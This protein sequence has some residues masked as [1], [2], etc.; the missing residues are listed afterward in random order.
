MNRKLIEP[1]SLYQD[2]VISAGD[3][4]EKYKNLLEDKFVPRYTIVEPEHPIE[5]EARI[6]IIKQDHKVPKNYILKCHRL[7]VYSYSVEE[8]SIYKRGTGL[9]NE[10][11][12]NVGYS[13][14]EVNNEFI[15]NILINPEVKSYTSDGITR[16]VVN[17]GYILNY[18]E[19]RLQEPRQWDTTIFPFV[20]H[21]GETIGILIKRP[22]IP[23]EL[24]YDIV[25]TIRLTGILEFK[26]K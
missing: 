9:P 16:Y 8:S 20:L 23:K 12:E 26:V 5:G 18:Y 13:I 10:Y 14:Q 19:L 7:I 1:V 24:N 4:N 17:S 21:E 3:K 22:S 6:P 2:I 15:F 25:I 11:K